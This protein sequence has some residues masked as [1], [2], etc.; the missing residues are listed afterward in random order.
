[1]IRGLEMVVLGK[2]A[3]FEVDYLGG[4]YERTDNGEEVEKLVDMTCN[5]CG[6]R[7][8]TVMDDMLEF[9]PHCG[10]FER[11]KFERFMEL[12][13]WSREQDWAFL[14][15]IKPLVPFAVLSGDRWL[16]KLARDAMELEMRGSFADVKPL[17][18]ER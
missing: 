12:Q 11:R 1:M 9:C 5:A 10:N 14:T 6:E 13:I 8:Y 3:S 17:N 2:T 4:K 15:H 18:L 16:L 7:Y